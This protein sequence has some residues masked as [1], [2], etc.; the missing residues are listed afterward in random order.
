MARLSIQ[1]RTRLTTLAL[2][3]WRR[4]AVSRALYSPFLK[5]RY[6][7]T[8]A[9][10]LLIVPQS[11]RT[12]DPSF[13]HEIEIGQFG[14]SGSLVIV[15]DKSPFEVSPPSTGWARNLHG[16]GWLR[17]LEAADDPKAIEGARRLVV[18]WIKRHKGGTGLPWEA[19]VTGR[20]LI[21]WITH[22]PLLL[23][24]ADPK[25]YDIITE[26]LGFQIVRLSA[27]WRDAP[28]G[29]PRLIA[30]IAVT[31]ADLAVAGHQRR[32][33]DAERMLSDELNK[34]ILPDGGHISR[35]PAVLVDLML[36]LLPL[37][38]CFKP[39][40]R[41]KPEALSRA[42]K[43]SLSMLRYMRMGDGLL[44][45]FNG[46][47]VG[48]VA[49]L[50]TV[51]AYDDVNTGEV[52]QEEAR[53]SGYAR[54]TA[55]NSIIIADVGVPPELEYAAQAHAGA[56]SF[57]M[58]IGK[59][60]VF[61]NGGAPSHADNEW[62]AA[63]RATAA[64]NTLRLGEK[65]SSK[66]VRHKL[67][68]DLVGEMPIRFPTKVFHEINRTSGDT[69]LKSCHDGYVPRFGLMHHR[70]LTLSKDGT[71]LDGL[72][73]I[74]GPGVSVRL[75]EDLPF[76]IHFHLHPDI[77]IEQMKGDPFTVRLQ[78]PDLSTWQ[79]KAEG[80]ELSIEDSIFF[81]DTSGAARSQQIVL[82]GATFGESQVRWSIFKQ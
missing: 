64:H 15:D 14:L 51:L 7:S 68:K 13:W 71:K 1:E 4:R 56:L 32:L 24:D 37:A 31:L 43:S 55:G 49:G 23:E 66:L 57:E 46:A 72:D 5:W 50:A 53:Y 61:V 40:E 21:S 16:F 60:L 47:G 62:R 34:Q 41:K 29:M 20:R 8:V 67:F 30:L 17:H 63:S 11:L 80:A 35:N 81:A 58:C 48:S 45:R 73:R 19:D 28:P 82:R 44:A 78:L 69:V 75:R 22:A 10:Q 33:K 36:D 39:R 26:S 25:T 74:D 79:F 12:A 18:D 3:R 38:Q 27:T 42:I 65:S 52:T 54:L 70:E 6:G 2:D 9:D 76:A 59:D 77:T